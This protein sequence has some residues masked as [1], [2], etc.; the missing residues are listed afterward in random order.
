MHNRR[1]VWHRPSPTGPSRKH[2]AESNAYTKADRRASA[3]DHRRE[4]PPSDPIARNEIYVLGFFLNNNN[5]DGWKKARSECYNYFEHLIFLHIGL[6][7]FTHD[8]KLH[9]AISARDLWSRSRS[10]SRFDFIFG[11]KHPNAPNSS[12]IH[13]ERQR[14]SAELLPVCAANRG[15]DITK[16]NSVRLDKWHQQQQQLGRSATRATWMTQC[17]V[18]DCLHDS[19]ARSVLLLLL[20]G[21]MSPCGCQS[22][23]CVGRNLRSPGTVESDTY[24]FAPKV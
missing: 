23:E 8:N 18:R 4:S 13:P 1:T 2:R 5:D 21:S 22:C 11:R 20:A 9:D 16:A 6:H 24:I 3:D 15:Y 7:G 17:C 19:R 10:F 14:E 12:K